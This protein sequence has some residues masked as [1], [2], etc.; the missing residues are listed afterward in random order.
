[1]ARVEFNIETL[2]TFE[3][4]TKAAEFSILILAYPAIPEHRM[5]TS[6]GIKLKTGRGEGQIT[7]VNPEQWWFGIGESD[8]KRL[9]IAKELQKKHSLEEIHES[10]CEFCEAL[11]TRVIEQAEPTDDK[12]KSDDEETSKYDSGLVG[13]CTPRFQYRVV[14]HPPVKEKMRKISIWFNMNITPKSGAVNVFAKDLYLAVFTKFGI[15]DVTRPVH[16]TD[17][18]IE[19]A[20][21]K[22]AKDLY[23]TRV[24]APSP[25]EGRPAN[26]IIFDIVEEQ[27][28]TIQSS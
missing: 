9:P 20:Y 15:Q 1:M 22:L 2:E 5:V 19:E 8:G 6:H 13:S 25:P 7:S 18:D 14:V 23:E 27:R 17:E 28:L 24:I 10:L 26:P 12:T 11:R 3:V 4:E 16:V 21:K